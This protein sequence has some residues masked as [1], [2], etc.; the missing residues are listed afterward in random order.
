MIRIYPSR[1]PGE[2]LETHAHGAT[3]IGAWLARNVAGYEPDIEHPISIDIDGLPVHPHEWYCREIG[4]ESDV[5]IYPVPMGTGLEI[6]IWAAVAVAAVSLAYA[7]TMTPDMAGGA[8]TGDQMDLN[9]AKANS[10]KLHQPVREILG[11]YRVYPDYLTQ[12]VTRF[13]N[14]RTMQ[15][16]MFLSVG[17]GR[18]SILPSSIKI[19]DTPIAAFGS[20]ASLSIYDPGASVISD[21]R[22][23][24]W[25]LCG[26]VGGT[27]AGTAGLDLSSTAPSGSS[28]LADAL[29]I[30]GLSVT[31]AGVTQP[32]FPEAWDAGTIVTLQT[33]NTF[34]V[35]EVA[36]YSRIAGPLADLAPFV[37]Q[38]VTL[39]AGGEEYDLAVASY[40]PYVAPIP[41]TGGSP[42]YAEADTDPSTYDFTGLP[43]VWTVAFQGSS[44]TVSLAAN[45]L[46]M[47]GLISEI[48]AQLSGLGL[49]AQDSDGRLRIIEPLSPY[50]G[51]AISQSSA[52]VSL[53]GASPTYVEGVAST[54]GSAE[55]DAFVT[56]KLD[57][58][59]PFI[60]L[61][62]GQQRLA[63][64]YRGNQYRI[65]S[66]DGL[67]MTVSRL[68]AAGAV[69]TGWPGFAGRTLIDFLLNSEEVGDY[70]W[71]GPFMACPESEVTSRIE[72]DIY[73]PQGLARYKDSGSKRAATR[74]V[75]L[76]WRD[77][78]TNGE[79]VTVTHR[80]VEATPDAIGFTHSLDLPYAMRPQVRM[81]RVQQLGG[82][83][84]RDAINW[85]GLRCALNARATSY[86]GLTT[87]A[88]TIRT[89]DRLGAQSDR[90]INLVA[91]RLYDGFPV[92]SVTG[93]ALCV[94]DSLGISRDS[95][96][97]A[98]LQALE[99]AYWT[100]RG[101]RFDYAATEQ[102]TVRDVLQMIFAAG[103]GH[104]VLSGGLISAIREGV[105]QPK[106]MITPHEMTG[107]LTVG[108]SVPSAD[109]FDGVDV[110]YF[111]S[112]TWAWETVP[113]RLPGSQGAK[114]ENIKL[115]GVTDET[116]AWRIG[117]RRLRKHQGQR[118]TFDCSTEMDA[119]CYEY[120]DHV[121]LA[122]DIPG[123][124][125]S[126]LI[127]DAE[128]V[129]DEAVLTLTE[130]FDWSVSNP[131][132]L[133]RRHDGTVTGLATPTRI[134][135]YT[136][137]V[138]E[139]L[140]DFELV[141]DLSI[142]PARLLFAS[143]SRVGYPALISSITPD[144]DGGCSVSA[145]EY[146]DDYYADDNN[147][148]T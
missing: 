102:S 112:A 33:P 70:N 144:S 98:Q 10:V 96:D 118:L 124:T 51:G 60:G 78:G 67:T 62:T 113:C 64:G 93:A 92:R 42:S 85:Y 91:T 8:A 111:S 46:N 39:S 117:M 129:G 3:T 87:I 9:S 74:D 108:F 104:L 132:C 147:A 58:G 27:D 81:R 90:K 101:E 5:R 110:K 49:V 17:V 59:S 14:K 35:T 15:T 119:L 4:A 143:S 69:D 50:Q 136:L 52:P 83:Q 137:S 19:G 29:V 127:V 18:H 109:D 145:V 138:P 68:N 116:R 20:D 55:Q 36:G 114:V 146:S 53:F 84:V 115:E 54:G 25:Y 75:E 131:R 79:W 41:G 63:I 16:G 97:V 123:T 45:Y 22:S 86:P 80:Y 57:D 107:E 100:P 130:A 128:F 141:T 28:V 76:Q 82:N 47:S 37:G 24:N 66:I 2:P 43:A 12:P 65:N 23:E 1:L 21:S 94:L 13:V 73:F 56:L 48:T 133:I 7:L 134:D 121:V 126:A 44:R 125:Q 40:S 34:E 31:L 61:P 30:S 103:M 142:E 105:Q 106:G 122:D 139:S 77:A 99:A 71:I 89:G 26:E 11:T 72:Y 135:D 32:E 120:L 88:L 140:I 6:A 148:P 95:V 38:L